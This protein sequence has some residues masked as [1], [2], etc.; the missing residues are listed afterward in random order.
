L[1]RVLLSSLQ[2]AAITSVKIGG[3]LHEFSTIPGVHE[4]VADIVL[5]LKEVRLR[6]HGEGPK[7]LRV[8]QKGQGVL[9]AKDLSEDPTVEVMNPDK[10]IATLSAD[11][12][13]ELEL[14]STRARATWAPRRTSPRTCRSARSRSTRSSRPCTKVNYS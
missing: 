8:H 13:V 1:R 9:R 14:T 4:D 2:G 7:V 6:L 10:K 5:N 11:A 3:V 12:D